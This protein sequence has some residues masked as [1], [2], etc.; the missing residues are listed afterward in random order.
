MSRRELTERFEKK[1]VWMWH[2]ETDKL[3]I[4]FPPFFFLLII[5]NHPLYD[6]LIFCFFLKK[7]NKQTVMIVDND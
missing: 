6:A 3:E 5:S 2:K 4:C 1:K 7:T